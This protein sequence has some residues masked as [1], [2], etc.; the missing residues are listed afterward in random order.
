MAKVIVTKDLR[1]LKRL[2]PV[3]KRDYAKRL[4]TPLKFAILKDI[5]RG[6]S[7]VR[8][9]RF[10]KYSK[11][12]KDS[13]RGR[14]MFFTVSGGGGAKKIIAIKAGRGEK[15]PTIP[16]LLGKRLSPVNLKLTGEMLSSLQVRS[17]GS[18]ASR[19]VEIIFNDEVATFH[20]KLGAG[21]S[22]TIRRLLPTEGGEQFNR[23]ISRLIKTLLIKSVSVTLNK[24]NK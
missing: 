21:K 10:P 24:F 3:I 12:Y 23:R 17:F 13:I 22:K 16:F 8:G 15:L 4:V 9:K 5:L 2:V 11:S 19:K 7:P 20:N 18:T 6:V 14:V 1:N